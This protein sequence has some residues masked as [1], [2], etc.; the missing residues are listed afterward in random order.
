MVFIQDA[1]RHPISVY[2]LISFIPLSRLHS[3]TER[4][5]GA[6]E[7]LWPEPRRRKA[8]ARGRN[9]ARS[10]S[11]RRWYNYMMRMRNTSRAEKLPQAPPSALPATPRY[12]LR[13]SNP[14]WAPARAAA[15]GPRGASPRA[16][17][18]RV[19]GAAAPA[20]PA[21]VCER[22]C[23]ALRSGPCGRERGAAAGLCRQRPTEPFLRAA[24]WIPKRKLWDVNLSF[25]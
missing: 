17:R 8:Q 11:R 14:A 3:G 15:P 5:T 1:P 24:S 19:L 13:R 9:A 4:K 10:C 23:E 20:A 25:E 18:P 22:M 12:V 6:W 21:Y 16:W 7:R 2:Y